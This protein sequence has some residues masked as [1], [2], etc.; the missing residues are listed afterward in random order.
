MPDILVFLVRSQVE[1]LRKDRVDWV[2]NS[3]PWQAWDGRGKC[4][5]SRALELE[6]LKPLQGRGWPAKVRVGTRKSERD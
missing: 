1:T 6:S 5:Q 2:R 4:A 3:G